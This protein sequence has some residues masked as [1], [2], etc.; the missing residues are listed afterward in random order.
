M[1]H[2]VGDYGPLFIGDNYEKENEK[3]CKE[4]SCKEKNL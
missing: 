2:V 3:S 1:K 4:A